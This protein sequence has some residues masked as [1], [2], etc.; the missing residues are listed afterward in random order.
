MTTD[1]RPPSVY[2]DDVFEAVLALPPE[3][4]EA[5]IQAR[6]AG[7]PSLASDVRAL[8]AAEE[9]SSPSDLPRVHVGAE[10]GRWP[11]WEIRTRGRLSSDSWTTRMPRFE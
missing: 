9:Q 2:L 4:R 7:H 8:I 1:N 6:C 10:L 11:S 5:A 3:Q